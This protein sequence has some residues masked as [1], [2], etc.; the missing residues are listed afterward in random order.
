MTEAVISH[1]QEAWQ[2]QEFRIWRRIDAQ[3]GC[4]VEAMIRT[5]AQSA[6]GGTGPTRGVAVCRTAPFLAVNRTRKGHS[7]AY[8][9]A[10]LLS[11][12]RAR[13]R[14][15]TSQSSPRKPSGQE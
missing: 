14:K 12:S 11:G 9:T 3:A 5:G 13:T 7:S 1:I 4:A 10:G 6:Y 8:S 15:P 2:P